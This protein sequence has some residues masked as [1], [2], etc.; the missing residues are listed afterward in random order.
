MSLVSKKRLD[1]PRNVL[2][3]ATAL[4]GALSIGLTSCDLAPEYHPQKF[5]YPDGWEGKGIMGDAR[6][7][8]DVNREDWWTAFN[9]PVLN[10]LET[11]MLATNPDLQAAAEAFTQ[12][13][14]VARETESRLYPQITGFGHM[15]ANKGS[16]GRLYNNPRTST[17]LVYESNEAYSG[18]ATW[19][20]DFWDAIRNSTRLHR[21]LAQ[22]SAAQYMSAK[23]SLE[24]ELA[25][26]YVALRGLDA[27]NAV[28]EDSIH[29]F[30]TAVQITSLRQEG[31]IGAGL[32]VSR[33]QNQLYAAMAAQ[34]KL[35]AQRRVL[36]NAIAILLNTA[37][38]GFHIA[39]IQN[40]KMS[41][42]VV[43]INPGL[44]S[45]LLE[46]RPDIAAAERRMSA[47]SK[48]IGVS[49]AAFYPHITLSVGG[50]FED[51]GFD[52]AS[53]SNA[54]WRVAVQAVEPAFTGG[55]RRAALQRAWSQYRETVDQYR[56]VVLSAFQDVENGLT[57]TGQL[58]KAQDEQAKAVAAAQRTQSMT[59]ALYTGG[60][61]NYLDAL[62]A[63]QDTLA[64]RLELVAT[65][66]AQVQASVRLMRA[67]GGGWNVQKLPS[68]D[69]INTFGPFQY[70][71]LRNPKPVAGIGRAP[72]PQDNDLRGDHKN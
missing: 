13:R 24:A 26:D 67:L 49:R 36:E 29:Y 10:D 68:T 32:D 40:V 42:G 46:R 56:S 6:P 53:I 71:G 45:T 31:A 7:A 23:L 16:D 58:K 52:L 37:P 50:G 72:L 19:E 44:P 5:L 41:L 38:A 64:A 55:L 43:K 61:S 66:T 12:A 21:N 14:D 70:E 8:D 3:S 60:L 27:Q 9:D 22:V 63:Q 20:P 18:A 25:S 62:V 51:G 15:S 48:A 69:Q 35:V 4:V 30:R 65:Q 59:M 54:F 2:R 34:S 17:S 33:A 39:P 57:Q 11:R 47:A 28:Y 1:L